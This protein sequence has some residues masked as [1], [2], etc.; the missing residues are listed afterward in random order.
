MNTFEKYWRKA[1]RWWRLHIE[2]PIK[3]I[4][5]KHDRAVHSKA[6]QYDANPPHQRYRWAIVQREVCPKCGK[7]LGKGK[8]VRDNL[9][10]TKCRDIMRSLQRQ[11]IRDFN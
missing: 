8:V 4:F 11:Q 10:T 3:Q 6:L 5:C 9:S 2:Q 1:N 7:Y